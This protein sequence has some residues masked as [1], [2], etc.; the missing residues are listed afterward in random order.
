MAFRH[1]LAA[2]ASA[3]FLA[4]SIPV[5]AAPAATKAKPDVAA[6]NKKRIQQCKAL[7]ACRAKYTKCA[8]AIERDPKKSIS[9]LDEQ[10]VKPYR[11]CI[12][13]H[14]GSFDMLFT[15]WFNPSYLKCE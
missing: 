15:R 13:K 12:N 1:V 7:N 4:V 2:A 8:N 11:A 14:F 5:A 3:A 9:L 10:C 6:A